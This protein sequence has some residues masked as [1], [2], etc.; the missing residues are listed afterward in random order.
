MAYMRVGQ[1]ALHSETETA[2]LKV[3]QKVKKKVGLMEHC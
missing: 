2:D 1:K 3:G